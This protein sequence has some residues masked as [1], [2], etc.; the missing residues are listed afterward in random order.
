[1]ALDDEVA[2]AV[3]LAAAEDHV[4]VSAWLS[5]A[6]R[7][8]LRIRQGLRGIAAW[9][10]KTGKLS[11]KE[12]AAGEALLDRLLAAKPVATRRRTG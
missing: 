5:E 3:V 11:R 10:S 12:I 4:S 2:D 7:Q 1:M 9:E 6:A 8:R